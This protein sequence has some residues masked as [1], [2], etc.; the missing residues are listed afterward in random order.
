MKTFDPAYEAH[1][2]QSLTTLA[3][4]WRVDRRDGVSILG[5]E[6]SRDIVIASGD[7]AGVYTA[8]AGI[9]GSDVRA[10]SDMSVT[11]MNVDGAF[12]TDPTIRDI[13][14]DAIEARLFDNAPIE[15][16]KVNW[17]APDVEQDVQV[18]GY[19]GEMTYVAEGQY[20][21]EVRG[22]TQRIQQNLGRLDSIDCD[23][24][25]FGDSTCKLNVAAL[26]LTGVVDSV[27]SRRRFNAT[28]GSI[29]GGVPLYYFN[30]GAF[31]FTTGD[32]AGFTKQVKRGAV[33][34]AQGRLDFWESFPRTVS[35]GDAFVIRPGCLRRFEDCVFYNNV[36]NFHGDGLRC[37]GIPKILRAP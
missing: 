27:T 11:N 17:Q 18:R 10:T 9:R 34:D 7:L 5:T 29:P 12:Q 26:E 31:R 19:L 3:R 21:T 33:D 37:P 1:L 16:F 23:V 2:Q 15:V 30:T 20:S 8:S 22:L 14:P 36:V 32:N 6:L 35:P 24:M 28:I 13:S 25:V 4:C